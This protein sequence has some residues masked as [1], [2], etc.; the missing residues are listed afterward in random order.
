MTQFLISVTSIEEA[1]IALE[2]GADFIDLK[3]PAQGALGALPLVTISEIVSYVK[4]VSNSTR[5]L[6][7]ATIGDLPMKPQFIAEQVAQ[8]A[9]T[10]VDIIKIGFF[11]DGENRLSDY[12]S[13]LSAL[14]PLV[15]SGLKLI[16]V[17]FAEYKY[18]FSLISSIKNAGFYGVMLDT[19]IKNGTTF[20]DYFTEEEFNKFSQNIRAHN[21]IFG[22]AGSL[23]IQHV[24]KVKEFNPNYVGFRGGVCVGNQRKFKLDSAKIT[25]IRKLL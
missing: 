25:A 21:L 16:A 17:L 12:E 24:V 22:L 20:L 11:N 3:D 5:K 1:E 7:S 23:A 9:K 4:V 2:N 18:P 19:A 14:E 15:K 6:T 10:G 13:C 8:L